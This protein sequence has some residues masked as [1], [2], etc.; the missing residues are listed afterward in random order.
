MKPYVLMVKTAGSCCNMHC[1]YCYYLSKDHKHFMDTEI[2]E[3]M[4]RSYF[5]SYPGPIYSL[6]WHG[7]EPTLLGL[8]FYKTAVALEKKYLPKGAVC[9]NNLQTNGT[10]LNEE[11]CHFLKEENFDVGISIDGSKTIHERYRHGGSYE[12]IV[13]NIRML[14]QMGKQP[15][16]LCA[17]TEDAAANALKTYHALRDLK[18]GWIQFI[19]VINRNN[20]EILKPSLTVETY[21]RFLV[22]VFEEWIRNDIDQLG[23]QFFMELLNILSGGQASLCYLSKTCGRALI[24][25]YDGSIYSCDHFVDDGH[26]LGSLDERSLSE[27]IEDPIQLSFG[28]AKQETLSEKCRRCPYLEL[29]NG[30]CP[31]DRYDRQYVLCEGLL[32]FFEH[33]MDKLKKITE[34]L[35]NKRTLTEV[36]GYFK[37]GK[38]DSE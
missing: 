20:E 4:I 38:N 12:D 27:M 31:K 11:W 2:L 15:D 25:E 33:E 13:R 21:G 9:W 36:K 18:T 22:T 7:G 14:Q 19:P 23:I 10:L 5:A 17:L 8:D 16:L 3:K 32:Y 24:V 1:D 28:A 37:D 29:C 26:R 30:G 6:V 34:M 35:K